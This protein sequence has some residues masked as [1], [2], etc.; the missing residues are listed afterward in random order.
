MKL[1]FWFILPKNHFIKIFYSF[2]TKVICPNRYLA[3][4]CVAKGKFYRKKTFD[5]KIFYQ[6]IISPK[7]LE[8]GP[9]TEKLSHLT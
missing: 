7:K 4:R 6:K 3:E 9:L 2:D 8:N 1:R 5:R